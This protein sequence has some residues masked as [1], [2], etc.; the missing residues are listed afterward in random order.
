MQAVTTVAP[1]GLKRPL[2]ITDV[3]RSGRLPGIRRRTVYEGLTE[4]YN[5][6]NDAVRRAPE[7]LWDVATGI[8]DLYLANDYNRYIAPIANAGLV[9]PLAL[10]NLGRGP[11]GGGNW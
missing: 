3:D 6:V 1:G 8:A 5:G 9:A 11:E 7:P 10:A 4:F 2:E